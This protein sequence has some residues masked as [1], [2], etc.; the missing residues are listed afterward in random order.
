M[1]QQAKIRNDFV[2]SKIMEVFPDKLSTFVLSQY[3]TPP[4]VTWLCNTVQQIFRSEPNILE[5]N[6]P[7]IHLVGDI[8][9]HFKDL[10]SIFK[11]GGNPPQQQYIFLGDYVDRGKHS[12][13]VICLLFILKYLYPNSVHML[14]GNHECREITK[15]YGFA[16]ECMNKLNKKC[17]KAFY[18]TFDT[19][20]LCAIANKKVFCVHGGIS[21]QLKSMQDI[22]DINRFQEIP[23][24]GLFADLLWSDPSKSLENWGPSDR[25]ETFLWGVESAKTFLQENSLSTIVRGHQLVKNGYEYVFG[26]EN[27]ILTIFSATNY[28]KTYLNKAIFMTISSE[29]KFAFT[30]IPFVPKP[31]KPTMKEKME[32]LY[33]CKAKRKKKNSK[34]NETA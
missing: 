29:M 30:E 21:P 13:E 16:K 11:L 19:I 22:K 32:E 15:N 27:S 4:F 24:K 26:E 12:V 6:S 33:L 14:R 25:C 34:K 7:N 31:K 23:L 2:I 8:H 3:L 5:I 18:Q 10:I 17:K 9:G 1:S 28:A 20:P